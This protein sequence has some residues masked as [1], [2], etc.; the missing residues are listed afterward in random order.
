M[1][2]RLPLWA[3]LLLCPFLYAPLVVD[4]YP[5]RRS[6]DLDYTYF[7]LVRYAADLPG[8]LWQFWTHH[9]GI[10][11]PWMLPNGPIYS[12]HIFLW[13]TTPIFTAVAITACSHLVLG[14]FFFARVAKLLGLSQNGVALA[15]FSFILAPA[16]E[17]IFH[18]DALCGFLSWTLLPVVLFYLMRL[19][20]APSLIHSLKLG[21]VVGYT[22]LNGHVGIS[23]THSVPFCIIALLHFRPKRFLLLLVSG[24]VAACMAA[25]KLGLLLAELRRFAPD[26][27]RHQDALSSDYVF[28]LWSYLLRPIPL[29]LSSVGS[30]VDLIAGSRTLSLGPIFGLAA[31]CGLFLRPLGQNMGYAKVGFVS[32]V[33][34]MLAP[35]AYLPGVFSANWTFRDPAFCFGVL[36]AIAALEK[37]HLSVRGASLSKAVCLIHAGLFLL[38]GLCQTYG[39]YL[40]RQGRQFTVAEYNATA[41][42]AA[43]KYLA[44]I[45]AALEGTDSRRFAL[46]GRASEMVDR[47]GLVDQGG[48]SNVA[49]TSNFYD[50]SFIAKGI[51]YD[52]VQKSLSLPYGAI[53]GDCFKDWRVVGG[54]EDWVVNDQDRLSL[55]GIGAVVAVP[56]E[57]V[58]AAHLKSIGTLKGR[59]GFE[60]QVYRNEAQIG[61][62]IFTNITTLPQR[63][64]CDHHGF[65]CSDISGLGVSNQRVVISE[66]LDS[67]DVRFPSSPEARTLILPHLFREEWQA[68]SSAT[69]IPIKSWQGL[70]SLDVPPGVESVKLYYRPRIQWVLRLVTY[71][72]SL[73]AFG[74]I[75]ILLLG[76]WIRRCAHSH[77]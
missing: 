16:N 30:Y 29:A 61:Q 4:S 75:L 20:L 58:T 41:I 63:A 55:L 73:T 7:A 14:A 57:V 3:V 26:L 45:Q 9:I 35:L 69:R 68:Q 11:S 13:N 18:A 23:I 49:I 6:E 53:S 31:L 19:L 74:W 60:L 67:L 5:I 1:R 47:E 33:L 21:V 43:N 70:L 10:G 27:P 17:Y 66:G 71:V 50:V 44:L 34:L 40:S 76:K 39:T 2:F 28:L 52:S 59:Y 32:S 36:L 56:G 72:S 15:T 46:T 65:I 8:S 24:A 77:L 48:L 51:S 38:A 25:D 54:C 37:F 22:V 64:A 12:P 62:G 42:P